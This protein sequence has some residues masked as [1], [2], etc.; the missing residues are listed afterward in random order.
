MARNCKVITTCFAGRQVR[1]ETCICGDPPGYFLHAQNF[2]DAESVLDLLDLCL[3]FER[4]IDPGAECDT[5]IVNND[6]GWEKG[7][8]FLQSLEGTKTF[9]GRIRVL[10]HGNWGNSFGGNACAYERLRD[11]YDTWTFTEDDTLMTQNGWL[12]KCLATLH[13]HDDRAF[14]VIQGTSKEIAL[15]AHAAMGTTHVQ[16]LDAVKRVWGTLPHRGE[17]ES[18]RDIDNVFFGE[19][20]FSQLIVRLGFKLVQVDSDTPLYTYAYDYMREIGRGRL[21][22]WPPR[23]V[24]MDELVR[25]RARQEAEV[26]ALERNLLAAQEEARALRSSLSWRIT[27]PMRRVLDGILRLGGAERK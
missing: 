2:P 17:G 18:Q 4:K 12:A 26:A 16:V 1:E 10:T 19:V 11:E 22:A 15:H 5:V 13:R 27:G 6:V 25:L 20:L 21:P 7:N 24:P 23:L 3:E 14:V 9:A 8:R